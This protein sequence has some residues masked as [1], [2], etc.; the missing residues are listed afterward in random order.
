[1][2]ILPPPVVSRAPLGALSSESA[3]PAAFIRIPLA[4]NPLPLRAPS[5]TYVVVTPS[6]MVVMVLLLVST[7]TPS[8]Y[9][10]GPL[11]GETLVDPRML[12]LELPLLALTLLL[13]SLELV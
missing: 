11:D 10:S 8:T 6:L 7:R 4:P 13:P 5:S 12:I 2:R 9:M 1:M 3:P